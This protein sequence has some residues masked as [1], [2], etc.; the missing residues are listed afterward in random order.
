MG[1]VM[2]R[3]EILPVVRAQVKERL[4]KNP[5]FLELPEE[6]RKA[7]AK[8]TV[9]ALAYILGGEDGTTKPEAVTLADRAGAAKDFTDL[10][11]DDFGQTAQD[12]MKAS[13]AVFARE[14]SEQLKQFVS[15]VDFPKFVSGLIDGV[16]TAINSNHMQQLNA[17]AELVKNVAKS[18]EDFMKDNVTTN[19]ARD[20]LMNKY[21]GQFQLGFEDDGPKLQKNE[22]ADDSNM[23]D[24]FKDLGLPKPANTTIDN[25]TI[26][27]T[28]VPAVRRRMALDRQQLLATM[29]MMGVNRLVV[30]DGHIE[31]SVLFD[32]NTKD[33]L[34]RKQS[35]TGTFGGTQFS[36]TY[37]GES[38]YENKSSDGGLFGSIFGGDSSSSGKYWYKGQY[39]D[40]S[41]NLTVSTAR[42]EDSQGK[43][44][45]HVKLAGKVNVNFKSDYFPMER[46]VDVMQLQAIREKAP[47]A[48]AILPG[49]G[50]ATTTPATGATK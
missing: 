29:V 11:K 37:S 48:A 45:M 22:A 40:E 5:R 33:A 36:E 31:A 21:P 10:T 12:K 35:K 43:I 25:D 15:T 2:N 39:D 16:F 7:V 34:R 18:V 17:Y 49:A 9:T 4:L 47:G 23:P 27:N 32:V 28:L 50:T 38:G 42:S 26:E 13:G 19:N 3:S 30:T 46:M 41:V 44:D 20:H 1:N 8:D 24:F 6:Q 14:G